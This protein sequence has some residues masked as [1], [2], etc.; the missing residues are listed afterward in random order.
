VFITSLSSV[1]DDE[2]YSAALQNRTATNDK[3]ERVFETYSNGLMG[4]T[5]SGVFYT[6]GLL[7]DSEWLRETGVIMASALTISAITQTTFKYIAGR[8]RPYTGLGNAKFRPFSF[9]SDFVAFPSGHTIVAFTISTVLSERINNIYASVALYSAAALGGLSR[10]YSGNHWLSD[11]VFGGAL[12]FGVSSWAVKEYE[13][14]Q[15]NDD[16]SGLKVFPY[17]NGLRVV[18]TF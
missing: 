17:A 18:W 9:N 11:V 15:K 12:A 6:S 3:L 10:I 13:G 14:E 4:I 7:F 1:L 5:L 2:V 8:A 16:N